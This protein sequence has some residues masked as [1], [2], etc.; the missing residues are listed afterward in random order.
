M[1]WIV[2]DLSQTNFSTPIWDFRFRGSSHNIDSSFIYVLQ[3]FQILRPRMLVF[4]RTVCCIPSMSD[5]Q[6]IAFP[7]LKKKRGWNNAF[8][9]FWSQIEFLSACGF[10]IFFS[11]E[12]LKVCKENNREI[13]HG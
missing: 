11:L 13:P 2:I 12:N 7:K 1:L 6:G 4:R 8:Y 9:I 5:F 3:L 10:T